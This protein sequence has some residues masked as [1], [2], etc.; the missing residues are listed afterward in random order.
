MKYT[1]IYIY[2]YI[3]PSL[4]LYIYICKKHELYTHAFILHRSPWTSGATR[5]PATSSTYV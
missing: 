5:S 2:M 4:S 3:S 1:Y